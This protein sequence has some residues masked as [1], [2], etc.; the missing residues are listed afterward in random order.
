M[1]RVKITAWA[2][3]TPPAVA[4]LTGR[5]GDK[6]CRSSNFEEKQFAPEKGGRVPFVLP[7]R[8]VHISSNAGVPAYW[9]SVHLCHALGIRPPLFEARKLAL[10][11]KLVRKMVARTP[12]L[13]CHAQAPLH[14]GLP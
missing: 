9:F 13:S 6:F 14:R 12:A 7:P 11:H 4:K 3:E 2:K 1:P 8:R 5:F 10:S